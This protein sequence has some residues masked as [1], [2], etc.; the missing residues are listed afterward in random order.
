MIFLCIESPL[1]SVCTPFSMDD[2]VW[3]KKDAI[4]KAIV[5]LIQ[6]IRAIFESDAAASAIY[7]L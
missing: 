4:R 3:L 7:L 2:V 1:Y 5:R 6:V